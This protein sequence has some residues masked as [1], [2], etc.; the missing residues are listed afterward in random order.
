M[1]TAAAFDVVLLFIFFFL[2]T[3]AFGPPSPAFTPAFNSIGH[4]DQWMH[5]ISPGSCE[6]AQVQKLKQTVASDSMLIQKDPLGYTSKQGLGQPLQCTG[7][8]PSTLPHRATDLPQRHEQHA[9]K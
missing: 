4:G 9:L 6:A 8:N 1:A 3:L 2:A 7:P 5:W